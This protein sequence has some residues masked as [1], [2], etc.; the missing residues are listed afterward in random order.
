VAIVAYESNA[1][2]PNPIWGNLNGSYS[3]SVA[4]GPPSDQLL[5][6]RPDDV[7]RQY[8][9]DYIAIAGT[10]PCVQD[11]SQIHEGDGDPL[12]GK[13]G[14]MVHRPVTKIQL[15]NV[16]VQLHCRIF[17]TVCFMVVSVHLVITY[18]TGQK[19]E[20]SEDL[21]PFRQ[22]AYYRTYIHLGCW[23]IAPDFYARI[24]AHV[25][26]GVLY[27]DTSYQDHCS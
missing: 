23:N 5:D 21:F 10:F 19:W 6:V 4:K 25:P 27:T 3:Y 24:E 18:S 12:P 14:C 26:K 8:I 15:T 2:I 17:F 9:T 16:D 1:N 22:I 7:V 11:L 13:H 20:Y